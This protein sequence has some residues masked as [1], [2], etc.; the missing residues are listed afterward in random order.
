LSRTN[1][2]GNIRRFALGGGK[3]KCVNIAKGL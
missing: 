1:A 2:K 3:I